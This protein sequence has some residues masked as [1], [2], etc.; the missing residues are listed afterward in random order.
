MILRKNVKTYAF[1]PSNFDFSQKF[2]QN[3]FF[4]RYIIDIS[5]L[6]LFEEKNPGVTDL[7]HD[8]FNEI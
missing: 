7:E 5:I 8:I 4:L 1:E 6:N 2:L 3:L